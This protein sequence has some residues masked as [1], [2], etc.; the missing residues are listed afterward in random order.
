MFLRSP[1]RKWHQ[2]WFIVH[3]SSII[4]VKPKSGEIRVVLLFDKDFKVSS[5]F[6]QTGHRDGLQVSNLTRALNIRTWTRRK[7]EEWSEA[8]DIN[9]RNDFGKC[10]IQTNRFKSFAPVRLN[11]E[12]RWYVDGQHFMSD[13]ADLINYA[14]EEIY[15]TD[16]WLSPE[17]YLKR[18]K[19][20]SNEFRLD[21]LLRKKAVSISISI[22]IIIHLI[23]LLINITSFELEFFI[24]FPIIRLNITPS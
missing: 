11:Q 15:I 10:F 17:I 18:G 13:V 14:T 5:G 20:F 24:I 9:M 19:D 21:I 4:G 8:L 7:N 6:K 12:G 16:W 3:E 1:S 23:S 2:M 22:S